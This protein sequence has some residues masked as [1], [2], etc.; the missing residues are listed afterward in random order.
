MSLTTVEDDDD[1]WN[2][3]KEFDDVDDSS[4]S[5]FLGKVIVDI[6]REFG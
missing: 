4:I 3:M 1:L 2:F 5:V 6:T